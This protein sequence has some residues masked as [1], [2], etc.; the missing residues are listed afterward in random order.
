MLAA[1]GHWEVW[2][3]NIHKTMIWG[4]GKLQLGVPPE[5]AVA[6]VLTM[7]A[8]APIIW[9]GY[10]GMPRAIQELLFAAVSIA[11]SRRPWGCPDVPDVARGM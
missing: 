9:P 1:S 4:E 7:I 6:F 5:G 11:I 10:L 8:L 2:D 3:L